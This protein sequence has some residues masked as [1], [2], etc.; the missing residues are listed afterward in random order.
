MP[1]VWS[2]VHNVETRMTFA[3]DALAGGQYIVTGA[4]AGLGRETAILLSRC[5][6]RLILI[7]RNEERLAETLGMLAGQGHA[8][9][10]ASVDEAEATAE[11]I[12][13]LAKEHG[14]FNG[15][16]HSAGST[17]VVPARLIKNKHIDEVFGASVYGAFGIAR[18]AGKKGVMVDGGSIV[19]MSSGAAVRA[20]PALTAYCAAKSAI[21]GLVRALAAELASRRIR[22]NSIGAGAVETAMHHD[23]LATTNEEA[24]KEYESLHLLGFGQ[25]EDVANAALF[26]LSD[27]SKWITATVLRV[28]GGAA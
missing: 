9:H 6:G 23:F 15:I 1:L 12:Q 27:A 10:A 13:A 20:R 8:T 18:A 17:A 24:A 5:G 19:F 11:I 28:D 4:S 2:A 22:V 7:G 21:D 16:F 25:P 14:P 3:R 26:L